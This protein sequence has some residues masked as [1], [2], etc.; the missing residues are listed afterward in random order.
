MEP[1]ELID[2]LKKHLDKPEVKALFAEAYR[3][4]RAAL[5]KLLQET[6]DGKAVF[7]S[8]YDKRHKKY[9]A[10][11]L[12]ELI[13]QA[14]QKELEESAKKAMTGGGQQ[15]AEAGAEGKEPGIAELYALL[16]KQ[17]QDIQEFKAGLHKKDRASLVRDFFASKKLPQN[18]LEQAELFVREGETETLEAAKQFADTYASGI[19]EVVKARLGEMGYAP[20]TAAA[21][22][23]DD[24]KTDEEYYAEERK[25]GRM[26]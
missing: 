25:A 5:E 23:A 3:P 18:I 9:E 10:E 6:D 7:S 12:P 26:K 16:Q 19:E 8:L 13:K 11:K 14:L 22:A 1:K 15:K 4:D 20:P 2:E 17:S 21:P 24:K